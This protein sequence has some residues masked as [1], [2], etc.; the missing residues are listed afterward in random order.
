MQHFMKTAY[1]KI[2]F[3]LFNLIFFGSVYS[4]SK[5]DSIIKKNE[6][7]ENV[8]NAKNSIMKREYRKLISKG[9]DE[10]LNVLK[11]FEWF[12]KKSETKKNEIINILKNDL[13]V[14][15]SFFALEELSFDSEGF[16]T[17]EAYEDLIK[18]MIRIADIKHLI[19]KTV[20]TKKNNLINITVIIK[21][22]KKLNYSVDINNNGDWIDPEFIDSFF[23]NQ[24]LSE[25]NIS[26]NFMS[27]PVVDQVANLIFIS[28]N[29]YSKAIEIGLIPNDNIFIE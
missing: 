3:L 12:N 23:N 5:N 26:E 29:D 15:Y 17:S 19:K 7:N 16:D 6:I 4:Q 22:G 8:K 10:Y 2:I 18:N 1:K 25:L 11:S 28:K 24:L 13:E 27:L 14:N 20:V 9:K 21:N